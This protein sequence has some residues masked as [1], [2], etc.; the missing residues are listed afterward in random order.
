[1]YLTLAAIINNLKN[2]RIIRH[3]KK[4]S[5]CLPNDSRRRN[6]LTAF[7]L[8]YYKELKKMDPV[9]RRQHFMSMIPHHL[10]LTVE[11][12]FLLAPERRREF[13]DKMFVAFRRQGLEIWNSLSQDVIK[14]WSER[15][16]VL[17][18]IPIPG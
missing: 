4:D 16:N 3:L 6:P 18:D 11:Q 1:M 15:A 8:Q 10:H 17:N 9:Q 12:L 5:D 2:I 13:R 7:L 14:A